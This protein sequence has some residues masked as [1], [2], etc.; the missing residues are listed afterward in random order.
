M[1]TDVEIAMIVDQMEADEDFDFD[2][3]SPTFADMAEWLRRFHRTVDRDDGIPPQPHIDDTAFQLWL[4]WQQQ[5]PN[6]SWGTT[7]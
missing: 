2:A 7:P 6:R 1:T 3:P 5:H 4:E